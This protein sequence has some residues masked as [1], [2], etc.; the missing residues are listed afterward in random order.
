MKFDGIIFDMDGV[1]VDVSQS[2]RLAIEKTVN[3][4]LAEY[5][6][7]IRASQADIKALKELPGYNNDW[8]LSY[9]LIELLTAGVPRKN[10]PQK[11]KGV[12]KKLRESDKYQKIKDVFQSYYLGERLFFSSY[13][14]LA[15]VKY[16]VGLIYNEPS[17]LKFSLWKKLSLKYRLGVATGRP[18]FEALYALKNLRY[19]P[20]YIQET[21]VITLED[22]LREK[23]NPEPLITAKKRMKVQN[24]IYVGDSINDVLAAKNAEM[25]CIYVGKSPLGDF[26]ITNVNQLKEILL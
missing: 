24:P 8:D 18:R 12:D 16:P 11:A 4:F 2:Y 26:Q 15:P 5:S 19:L 14:R 23:P 22:V 7:I 10:F 25:K 20:D 13:N 21:S 3:Y 1:L 6:N 17:L 9:S